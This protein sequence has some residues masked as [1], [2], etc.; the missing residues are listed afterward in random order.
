MTHSAD[1]PRIG[2]VLGWR[3]HPSSGTLL[4]IG[5][6]TAALLA[7]GLSIAQTVDGES[8]A[9]V[10]GLQADRVERAALEAV[11]GE[12]VLSIE[13]VDEGAVAWKV[14]VF[15]SVE[16]LEPWAEKGTDGRRI[17]V[18]LDRN[19]EWVSA[20]VNGYGAGSELDPR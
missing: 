15:K 8:D 5:V 6:V 4:I 12:R 16:P 20:G 1:I 3:N 2:R 9:G 7:G 13:R 14:H 10:T 11:G 18:R 19:L 17:L